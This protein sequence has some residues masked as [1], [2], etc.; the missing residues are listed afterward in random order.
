MIWFYK[1]AS[2]G[3]HIRIKAHR[4]PSFINCS[5]R[6]PPRLLS[7]LTEEFTTWVHVKAST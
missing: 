5:G 3:L 1:Y 6:D 2:V 7:E 4:L